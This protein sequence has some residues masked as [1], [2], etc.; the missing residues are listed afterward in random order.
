MV[1]ITQAT[2]VAE[3]TRFFD[4]VGNRAA[5]TLALFQ[6]RVGYFTTPAFL[7]QYPTNISN[8]G[9]VTIDQTMI[10]GL[11]QAFDGTDPITVKDAPGLDPTHAANPACFGCHWNLDPMARFFRSNFTTNYSQQQ[12]P[13]QIAIPGTFLFDAV[14]GTSDT[15]LY[16]LADQIATHPQFK[17]AWTVKLCAWANSGTCLASDPEVQRVAQVFATSNYDWNT[18]VHELFTSPLVTNAS[19]TLT[20]QTEGTVVPIVR[21]AQLCATLDARLGLTDV[22]GYDFIPNVFGGSGGTARLPSPPFC[23]CANDPAVPPAPCA[24]SCADP[25]LIPPAAGQLP[26]DGYSRGVA[27]P[28]YINGPDPFWR[29][30]IEQICA[31]VADA[32]VDAGTTPLYSSATPASVTTSIASMA[33]GLMGLDSSRDAEPIS[34]LTSHYASALAGGSTETIALKST[35]T[36]ACLSPWVAAVGE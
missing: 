11:G 31:Y 30:S 23:N 35:F 15:S 34:I 27:A 1:T 7:A 26:V 10:V 19:P 2:S 33:H 22:C 14:V 3:Q 16:Y 32:V 4:I 17:T 12:D 25:G 36:A 6:Q 8:Q 20:A 24:S 13:A 18:L 21:R 28:L 29:S 5:N 9:R